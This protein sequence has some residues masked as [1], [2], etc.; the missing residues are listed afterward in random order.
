MPLELVVSETLLF[1]DK[2]VEFLLFLVGA[3]ILAAGVFVFV[4]SEAFT[5]R[6]IESILYLDLK[7]T[8]EMVVRWTKFG[9]RFG[10]VGS[11]QENS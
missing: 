6:A 5:L 3:T 10:T 1:P 8:A 11:T 2:L 9:Q 4:T 7:A